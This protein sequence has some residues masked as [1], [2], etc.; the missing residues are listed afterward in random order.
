MK[1]FFI[2]V[3]NIFKKVLI[4]LYYIIY[5]YYNKYGYYFFKC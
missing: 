5:F 4:D 3:I 2:L 1:I